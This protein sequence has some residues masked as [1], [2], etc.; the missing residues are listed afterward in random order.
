[1]KLSDRLQPLRGKKGAVLG[2]VITVV[3][4]T[5]VILGVSALGPSS[6]DPA[7][8]TLSDA[9]I[10]SL[11]LLTEA[12]RA[13]AAG[14]TQGAIELLENALI[15]NPENSEASDLLTRLKME[16]EDPVA[17][18]DSGA[19]DNSTP[20]KDPAPPVDDPNE[21][22]TEPVDDLSVLMPDAVEK[23]RM[24]PVFSTQRD[25]DASGDPTFE[26]ED[27]ASRIIVSVHDRGSVEDARDFIE[28]TSKNAYGDRGK[29]VTVDGVPA[30]F[31]TNG[32]AFATCAYARGRYVFEIIMTSANGAPVMLEELAINAASAFPDELP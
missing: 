23:W 27:L 18:T 20:A 28:N 3:L 11:D 8:D 26:I 30:Y 22:F 13:E 7:N 31:G 32:S 19:P 12:E 24:D 17:P 6:T 10:A 15:A 5:A 16:Q 1:M 25:A 2:A 29:T 9:H 14:D 4:A 21:G